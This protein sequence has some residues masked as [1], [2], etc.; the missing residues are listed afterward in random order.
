M[1]NELILFAVSIIPVL[2]IGLYVY[3]KDKNREPKV[4]LIK[5]FFGGIGSCFIVLFASL[6]LSIIFPIF[7]LNTET[8][9]IYELLLYCFICVAFIEE[10]SKWIILY[11]MSYDSGN[12]DELYDIIVYAVFVALGFAFFENLFYV[13]QNGVSVGILRAFLSVPGH[14]CDG[15]IMGYYLGL[16]KMNKNQ[17][18]KYI[19]YSIIIPVIMHG[20]YDFCLFSGILIFVIVFFIFIICVDIYVIRKIRKISKDNLKIKYEALYCINCG[21]KVTG[22]YCPMCGRKNN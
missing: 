7:S 18:K 21:T 9:N 20:I 1:N 3:K 8:A 14:C 22:N 15:V 12:F 5:L 11:G 17:K 19:A 16:A 13:Y 4:F 6:I 2:L 10:M